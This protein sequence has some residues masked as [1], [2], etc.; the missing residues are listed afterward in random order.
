VLFVLLEFGLAEF[1]CFGGYDYVADQGE[2][3]VVI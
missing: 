2:F 1:G 3:V